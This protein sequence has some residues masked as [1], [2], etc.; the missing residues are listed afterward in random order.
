VFPFLLPCLY[1]PFIDQPRLRSLITIIIV[2]HLQPRLSHKQP[3]L[4]DHISGLAY[5]ILAFKILFE[6]TLQDLSIALFRF[7]KLCCVRKLL[8]VEQRLSLLKHNYTWVH[9]PS[10]ILVGS[11]SLASTWKQDFK[12]NLNNILNT[13]TLRVIIHLV[14]SSQANL[15]RRPIRAE[16][17]KPATFTCIEPKISFDLISPCPS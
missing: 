12:L 8:S 9:C 16:V 2:A 1:Q 7:F 10:L 4:L 6:R 11:L 5:W 14:Y 3:S 17:I 15:Q 13:S